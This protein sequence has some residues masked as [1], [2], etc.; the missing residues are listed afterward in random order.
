MAG[1]SLILFGIVFLIRGVFRILKPTK[2]TM[3]ITWKNKFDSEPNEAY[4]RSIKHSGI[5]YLL[6][7]T[8]LL[9]CGALIILY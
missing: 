4:L 9:G 7:G 6:I 1:F 3:Y 8:I 5:T 2:S